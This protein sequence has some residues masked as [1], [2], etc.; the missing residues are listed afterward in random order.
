M[1]RARQAGVEA[2]VDQ[3]LRAPRPLSEIVAGVTDLSMRRD[4]YALAFSIVRADGTVT[5]AERI[6]LAQ[7]AALLGIDRETAGRLEDDTAAQIDAQPDD[8]GEAAPDDGA[9]APA[10]GG[11]E[12]NERD[13]REPA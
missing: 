11:S 2:L 12:P 7:L 5:G 6:Y 9:A 1:A 13:S 4:L 3:E 10:P 8:E